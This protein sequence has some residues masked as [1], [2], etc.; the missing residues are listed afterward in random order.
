MPEPFS[1]PTAADLRRAFPDAAA[2]PRL[3][4]RSMPAGRDHG[5]RAR[6]NM[7]ESHGACERGNDAAKGGGHL[8]PNELRA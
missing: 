4:G 5:G 8:K 2:S 3:R 6:L 7:P 1:S